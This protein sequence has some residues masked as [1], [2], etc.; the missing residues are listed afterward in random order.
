LI[1]SRPLPDI[2]RRGDRAA[3]LE[4]RT[5]LKGGRPGRFR[6]DPASGLRSRG[7]SVSPR[8]DEISI[9]GF[10]AATV[11]ALGFASCRV[12]GHAQ[13][14]SVALVVRARVRAR[15][16]FR[17][18]SLRPAALP[19]AYPLVGVT[20]FLPGRTIT[21]ASCRRGDL[22]PAGAAS[23]AQIA[24]PSACCGA[25]AWSIRRSFRSAGSTPCLRFLHRP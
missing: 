25:D 13:R 16:R 22:L 6:F 10:F 2:F 1:D 12:V 8:V 21:S 18:I 9:D 20:A 5:D 3:C 23:P 7:R 15:P 17:V 24:C 11:P 4:I 14:F 19:P